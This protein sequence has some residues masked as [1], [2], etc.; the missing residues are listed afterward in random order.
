MFLDLW[1]FHGRFCRKAF[2]WINLWYVLHLT[3]IF[4]HQSCLFLFDFVIMKSYC[5]LRIMIIGLMLLIAHYHLNLSFVRKI[6]FSF[7][8]NFL[9]Y[10]GYSL[11]RHRTFFWVHGICRQ[12]I[13]YQI[14]SLSILQ[15]LSVS[16][17]C[18]ALVETTGHAAL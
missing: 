9:F 5:F 4:Q 10:L 12:G 18:Y 17:I 14:P 7:L 8:P 3:Y 11:F 6:F 13:F 2:Y 16:E 1:L 15:F